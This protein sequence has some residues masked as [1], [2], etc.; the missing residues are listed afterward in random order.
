MLES[1]SK[2]PKTRILAE[3]PLKTW[4]KK[5]S[6]GWGPGPNDFSQKSLTYHTYDV[7]HKQHITFKFKKN[8]N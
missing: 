5:F 8:P 4:V 2:V 7:T 6:R 3:F 1:Q